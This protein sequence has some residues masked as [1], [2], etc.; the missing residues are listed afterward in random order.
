MKF[1]CKKN[2]LN[3]YGKHD[4]HDSVKVGAFVEIQPF[5]TI[6]EN[7]VISS[8]T[9]LCSGVNIGKNCFIGHGVMTINDLN[10]EANNEDYLFKETKIED[11]VSIGSG[12]TLLPVTI[13]H[14]SVVG[15]GA[16][17]TKDVPPYAIVVGNPA[18]IIKYKE[19]SWK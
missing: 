2:Q 8:H 6:G 7:S 1:K 15:A 5:V 10:P 12:V 14:D 19:E 3:I 17:V 13:G 9:F 16:V 18:K 4:F 11:N